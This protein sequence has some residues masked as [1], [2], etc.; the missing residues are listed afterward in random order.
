MQVD[1]QAG[2][3][4]DRRGSCS[5]AACGSVSRCGQPPTRSTPSVDRVAQQGPLSR[6]RP[7][8]SIGQP[9]KRA[10]P[11][12]STTPRSRSR[13]SIS[14]STDVQPVRPASASTWVRIAVHAVGQHQPR[15]TLG[16]LDRVVEGDQVARGRSI[17]RIAPIRSP[18]GFGTRSARNALSRWACGSANAGQQQVA[19]RR[20]ASARPGVERASTSRVTRRR[21]HRA[22]SDA[23][24]C[25]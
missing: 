24:A 13:T 2:L 9:V 12:S 7:A 4:G 15:G 25:R 19:V 5:L 14:A 20:P 1:R 23:A 10:R 22:C 11:G 3:G 21:A 6:R 18:V 16:A 17:A 8:R